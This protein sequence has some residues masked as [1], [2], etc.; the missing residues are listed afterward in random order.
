MEQKNLNEIKDYIQKLL[1][2][3]LPEDDRFNIKDFDEELT[4]ILVD[5]LIEKDETKKVGIY[6]KL[7]EKA[8]ILNKKI[9]WEYD[10]IV[11]ISNKIILQ[12]F[13]KQEEKELEDIEKL[14]DEKLKNI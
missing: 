10:E 12:K 6:K 3:Y 8:E 9:K 11:K 2:K 14:F 7:Y 4:F 1:D 5:L 13:K